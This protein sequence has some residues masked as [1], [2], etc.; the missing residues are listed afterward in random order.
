MCCANS[1]RCSTGLDG[2]NALRVLHISCRVGEQL[3][4]CSVLQRV[5][6]LRLQCNEIL[7]PMLVTVASAMLQLV[8]LDIGH[9]QMRCACDW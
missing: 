4:A 7:M 9:S 6:E 2:C 1:Q 3:P 8:T 5:T